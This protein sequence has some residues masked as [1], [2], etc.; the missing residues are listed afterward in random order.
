MV[1]P[2][3]YGNEFEIYMISGPNTDKLYNRH[4]TRYT[5]LISNRER[6]F[7]LFWSLFPMKVD[8]VLQN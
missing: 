8:S 5:A 4:S 7:W 1:C 6:M 3:H 2:L